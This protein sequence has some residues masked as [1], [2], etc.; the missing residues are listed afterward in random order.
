MILFT[1]GS[2]RMTASHPMTKKFISPKV[3]VFVYIRLL[4]TSFMYDLRN[5]S[6]RGKSSN[7]FIFLLY[8]EF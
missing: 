1:S 2:H 5:H 8:K 4:M 3:N 6:L 7:S